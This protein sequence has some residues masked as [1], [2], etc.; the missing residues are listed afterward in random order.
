MRISTNTIFSSAV[1]SMDQQ[2]ALMVKTQQQIS[3]GIR[4][5]TAADDPAAAAQS[6]TVAQTSAI[7]T[8]FTSNRNAAQNTLSLAS[9]AL[10]SVTNLIQAV[11]SEVIQAGNGSYNNSDRSSIATQLSSQLQELVGLANSTD[12]AGNYLFSGFQSR[13]QPF[14]NTPAGIGYFG[15][16]GQRNIQVSATQQI[17]SSDTGADV[18]M[19]IRNG[20]GT[21]ATQAGTNSIT[22]GPNQGSGVIS[23][24]SVANPPPALPLASYNVTFAV[25]PGVAGAPDVTTYTVSNASAVPTAAS[26][27]IAA[28]ATT[29]T[30]A[31]A[32]GLSVGDTIVIAGAGAA[33]PSTTAAPTAAPATTATLAS[34]A[35][36]APGYNI[37]IGGNPAAT[38]TAI[39][40][41]TVTFSPATTVNTLATDP[42]T[43]AAPQTATITGIAGNV[44]T[45]TPATTSATTGAAVTPV[46]STGTPYVSGQN[47]SFAGVQ[48]NIQGAPANGDTFTVTPSA[49][50]SIFKTISNLITA[51]NTPVANAANGGGTGLN[52]SLSYGLNSLGNALNNILTTQASLGS[53]QN[54]ISS[55]QTTGDNLGVQYQSALTQLQGVDMAKAIS[56]LT[57]QQTNLQA[58]QKSFASVSS[59][60]LFSY[61]R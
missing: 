35:G 51:L 55:L 14:V 45:F 16:N 40:G 28:G 39:A 12:G 9:S 37:T 46:I 36:L 61:L 43:S 34:V 42:V 18:F 26:G 38:I 27:V 29:A 52:N 11:Q 59:L 48:F 4:L 8:Q 5:Q 2:Q 6:L 41:N 47:I 1:A 15:D 33:G 50:E 13:T 23:V 54:E 32:A 30:V 25:T 49:N 10:Q 56:D 53:R 31:S 7:N 44:L 19:R 24:G 60:S 57:Q 17:A 58:A 22:S 3:S 21:F 20:N